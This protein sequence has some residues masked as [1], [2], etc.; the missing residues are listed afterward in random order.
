MSKKFII[1]SLFLSVFLFIITTLLISNTVLATTVCTTLNSNIALGSIDKHYATP[2]VT[3]LQNFLASKGLLTATPNGYFGPA[4]QAAIQTFQRNN[5]L[6]VTGFVGPLTR[7]KIKTLSCGMNTASSVTVPASP[8]AITNSPVLAPATSGGMS[9]RDFVNLMVIIGVVTP[10][11][12]PGINA[13]LV[14]LG[15][16]PI[17][18]AI[19]TTTATSTLPIA[20]TTATTTITVNSGGGGG[21]GSGNSSSQTYTV[22]YNGNGNTSGAAPTDSTRYAKNGTVTVKNNTGSLT[23]TGYAF[24]G[25]NTSA[26]GS[27]TARTVASTFSVG[28]A[29]VTLYAVWVAAPT[30]TVTYDANGGTGTAPTDS[31]AYTASSTVN[32]SSIGTLTKTG[33][34]F[35]GWNTSANGSGTARAASSTFS[36][37]SANVTL[38]AVW[39]AGYT[40]TYDANGGTGTVPIDS[41]AYLASST[42]TVSGI[43]TL[44]KTGYAL[45]SWNTQS[46]GSGTAY[47][48]SS[49]FVI[50]SAN[51]I[52]YA[53][54]T[55]AY[56]VTYDGNTN[57]GGATSTDSTPYLSG[58]TTTVLDNTGSLVKTGYTFI[59]WNTLADGTGTTQATSSTLIIASANVTLYAQWRAT[60]TYNG[61][62]NTGGTVPVDSNQYKPGATVTVLNNTGSLVKTGYTFTSWN[63]AA[64]GSGTARATSSTFSITGNTILYA[65]WTADPS[66]T[67]TVTYYGNGNTGGTV[68]VDSGTYLAGAT[69]TVLSNTG[70]LVKTGY[71]FT[72]WN[73]LANGSGTARATSSTI[74]IGS[75]NITLYAKWT[76]D[77][78]STYTV[79]YNGNGDT[80][81][82]IPVD[83]NT[84]IAGATVTVLNNTGSL[85]KTGSTFTGWNTL[86]NG[87]GTN[88][89]T[90]STFAMGSANVTLYAKW[91]VNQAATYSVTYNG[92]GNTGGAVPTDSSTYASGASVTVLSNPGS[93]FKRGYAF[94]GWNF[95]S[96]PQNMTPVSG[97]YDG[98]GKS[99]MASWDPSN[100]KWYVY[101]VAKSTFIVWGI[102][103]GTSGMIPVSGDYDGD[104]VSDL[105]VW[106]PANFKWYVYSVAKGTNIVW[107]VQHGAIGMTPVPGD[108]DG[109]GKSDLALWNPSSGMWYIRD[110]ANTKNIAWA[111]QHGG[112]GMIPVSGDYDG[113][114][115]SDLALWDPSD[116]KWYIRDAAN[117]KTIAWAVVW[118]TSAMTPVPGDYDG[119]NKSDLGLWNSSTGKWYVYSLAKNA[120]LVWDVAWGT[121]GMTP[122]SGDYD[123]DN[124][125]DLG[126]WNS[127]DQ[128]WYVRD[129]ANTTNIAYGVGGG[130]RVVSS[131]F[132]IGSTNITL[133][134]QWI[135]LHLSTPYVWTS[136]IKFNSSNGAIVSS[137]ESSDT[138]FL[139]VDQSGNLKRVPGVGAADGGS[140]YWMT[141]GNSVSKI[142]GITGE[143][144][145]AYPVGNNP[146]GVAVDAN[147][148]V[149]VFNTCSNSVTKLKSST[150]EILGTYSVGGETE[151]CAEAGDNG[152]AVDASN[153]I[154]ISHNEMWN[155]GV[156]HKL[157][158][159]T[160]A[161]LGS[162]VVGLDTT[163]IA[164]DKNG[165]AW[166]TGLVPLVHGALSKLNGSNGDIAGQYGGTFFIKGVAVD[167]SGNIWTGE[168]FGSISKYNGSTGALMGTYS[169]SGAEFYGD[170]TGF[171]LLYFTL[172]VR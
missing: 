69:T 149:F 138:S 142:D 150:G 146:F 116:G 70:S 37:G 97:D 76:A 80:A 5:G 79:T 133:Y 13:F 35:N 113:D 83:A 126:V 103:L 160:G 165:N 43:S 23:K 99:D 65:K 2:D 73:T 85:V 148:N 156:V 27:G 121:S 81:G 77:A 22:T 50:G 158:G 131:T 147:G 141:G 24:S 68:P 21:G 96:D 172:G 100:G 111:V 127:A 84:Y 129:A 26:D 164:I 145:G 57:T 124:K 94:S 38:Y 72:G 15:Q 34:A 31:N 136:Q 44:T 139:A 92:N 110:A 61:V 64:D 7:E 115:K 47:A 82:T 155:G 140:N 120:S 25:W 42:V 67:Y 52:L 119:D 123:G 53:Q 12:L 168:T 11:K 60:V 1:S 3:A 109:D 29:N 91:T 18:T 17:S 28:S 51:V 16:T 46:N 152:I 33:Y 62:A 19:S 169:A 153:N 135:L 130:D 151:N 20:T 6:E 41:N 104:G 63:T 105:A 88:R 56:Y 87:S 101:S 118:G 86:A 9:L 93:L 137:L 66:A 162:Y 71:T 161:H 163:G 117:T 78:V 36:I 107:A 90:S 132:T 59:G 102:T 112:T 114:G 54:W 170:A 98:D 122:V 125:S 49:T 134:A 143:L 10:D 39:V 45:T 4:T 166:V 8:T 157:N 108:Y 144:I 58:A 171:A 40:V 106:D 32:V 159:S 55:V 154:W 95:W 75:A 14:S 167:A 30:F 89:A 74:T 128:K 48:T